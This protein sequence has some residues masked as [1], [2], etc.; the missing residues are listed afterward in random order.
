[1]YYSMCDV[2]AM[3]ELNHV[4]FIINS[5]KFPFWSVVVQY[6]FAYFHI[7]FSEYEYESFHIWL[8]KKNKYVF[9]CTKCCYF[10]IIIHFWLLFIHNT[11]SSLSLSEIT[12]S[13]FKLN[14]EF[15]NTDCTNSKAVHLVLVHV[16][17][18]PLE[19]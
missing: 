18:R 8:E 16:T 2:T 6:I 15:S 12:L 9:F 17:P 4:V 14:K 19:S 5:M 13:C 7:C 10:L 1:M 11:P 3:F